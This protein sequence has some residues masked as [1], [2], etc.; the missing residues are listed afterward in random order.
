MMKIK[1][2]NTFEITWLAVFSTII[3]ILSVF[4]KSSFW[5]ITAY[6]SGVLCV[7]LAAKGNIYNYLFGIYNSIVYSWI[8][9]QNCLYGEVQLNLLFFV[10]TGIIGWLMWR[11]RIHEHT[12]IMRKMNWQKTL[13]M[14]LVSIAATLGYGFW[15]TTFK[16]QNTPYLDAFNVVAYIIATLAMMFRYREQWILYICINVG[17][18][19]MWSIRLVNGNVD[20]ATMVVMYLAYLVNSIYGF[21]VWYKGSKIE[22]QPE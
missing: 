6:I 9:Y 7:V 1:G 10:P 13:A 12:V 17:E 16:G 20:A 8:S 19:I 14:I 11:K 2:W 5:G 15:L 21:Y 3:V 22:T 4:W 18:T